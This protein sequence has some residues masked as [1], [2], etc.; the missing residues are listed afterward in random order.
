MLMFR[1]MKLEDPTVS[2]FRRELLTRWQRQREAEAAK[3]AAAAAVAAKGR[4]AQA[5]AAV[6]E[7]ARPAAAPSLFRPLRPGDRIVKLTTPMPTSTTPTT[8]P[9]TP[10]PASPRMEPEPV[11]AI[12]D[13]RQ[14]AVARVATWLRGDGPGASAARNV[15]PGAAPVPTARAIT[16]AEPEPLA[17]LFARRRATVKAA[18]P[19]MEGN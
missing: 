5:S 18:R 6:S 1:G 2:A 14:T 17:D 19:L 15:N 7:R 10:G 11:G 12:L 13:R 4:R 16:R 8:A 3:A 9:L